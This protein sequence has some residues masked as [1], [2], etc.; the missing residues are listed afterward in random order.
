MSE[1]QNRGPQRSEQIPSLYELWGESSHRSNDEA[2]AALA[3]FRARMHLPETFTTKE[4]NELIRF[5]AEV[6]LNIEWYRQKLEKERRLHS[7]YVRLSLGLLALVPAVVLGLNW[8]GGLL[9][10]G[11][12]MTASVMAILSGVLGLHRGFSAWMNQR[13]VISIFW[14]A[15][16]DLKELLFTMEAKFDKESVDEWTED[17][18]ALFMKEVRRTIHQ[19][20]V[21]GRKER[22]HFFNSYA[23]PSFELKSLF[24]SGRSTTTNLIEA[25]TDPRA[26]AEKAKS[27][28]KA[29]LAALRAEEAS[30]RFELD[31]WT[32]QLA[33]LRGEASDSTTQA[34]IGTAIA[35]I[36]AAEAALIAK[37]KEIAYWEA[38]KRN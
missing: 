20:R 22:T 35:K 17:D 38:L 32:A 8:L 6:H 15:H 37:Q 31:A 7:N 25:H 21:I 29:K 11:E 10:E 33:V 36:D 4:E 26:E 34:R 12:A 23:Y 1:Q 24:D 14:T 2:K 27:T 30:L 5:V 18:K 19:A 3:E 13:K 16:A 9:G 28:K